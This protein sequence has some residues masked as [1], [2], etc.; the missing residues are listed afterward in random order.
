MSHI[1]LER[2][3]RY[4]GIDWIRRHCVIGVVCPYH[5]GRRGTGPIELVDFPYASL[6]KKES[7]YLVVY[8]DNADRVIADNDSSFE[9]SQLGTTKRPNMN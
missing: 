1:G 9:L 4:W 6:L 7:V 8:G 5:D 3:R 2:W